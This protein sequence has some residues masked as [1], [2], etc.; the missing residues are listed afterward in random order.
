MDWMFTP[1][2]QATMQLVRQA[3]DPEQLANP[4]KLFPT[5]R[6]CSESARRVQVLQ[7]E[8]LTLPQEAL[9]Y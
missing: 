1:D 8:G 3:F 7:A 4:G 6:T 9:V 2:D 5:P